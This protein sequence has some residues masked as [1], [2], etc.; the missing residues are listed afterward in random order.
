MSTFHKLIETPPILRKRS[1]AWVCFISTWLLTAC[2][3]LQDASVAPAPGSAAG[4]ALA[5]PE[6]ATPKQA[7]QKS[8]PDVITQ[9]TAVATA[10][11]LATQAGLRMLQAGGSAV[12]AAVSAQMVLGLVEPQSSGLG[13]GAFLLHSEGGLVQAWDGRETAP[14]QISEALLLDP[15][16]KPL[17]FHDAVVGGRSVGTPGVL[18]M[19][20]RVHQ[21]HGKLPWAQLFAPAIELANNGFEV[22]PRLHASLQADKFLRLDPTARA[23]FYQPQGEP[24][25]VGYRLR[26]P[27][28]AKVLQSIAQQGIDAFYKGEV[29]QAMVN[30]VQQHPTNPGLLQLSDLENY[31]SKQRNPLC[32][33]HTAQTRVYR[34]CGMPPPSSGAIAIGQILGQ[35]HHTPASLFG[36]NEGDI[37]AR[38]M[39]LYMESARLA[40][41]DRSVYVADPDFVTAPGGDWMN[42]LRPDYLQERAKLIRPTSMQQVP[43][44]NPVRGERSS[45][46][47]MLSQPEY[48]TSHMSIVDAKGNALAMTTT[49]EDAF[50]ARQMVKGFLLNNQLTD[51]SFAPRNAQGKEI[52]NRVQP[53]K[54]PRSSMSPTL[55]FDKATGQLVMS[56]GSPGGA[57]I[58]H[59][60]A[61][62]LY[63]VLHWGLTPQQAIDLPNFGTIGGPSVLEAQRFAPAVLQALRVRGAEVREQALPSGLQAIVR[64]PAAQG[65]GWMS[66]SDARREGVAA[67]D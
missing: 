32:F 9:R 64:M 49:I 47:P 29:A 53:N 38:W 33:D 2:N 30:K 34:I 35:L 25:P 51:F 19:L 5:Q 61:K 8:K 41:A 7:A 55:V 54:R 3:H 67:G 58:I 11:P 63:G 52:A 56:T 36:L 39:H 17:P 42:L 15:Q 37:D 65:K 22:S 26:N 66:G 60:T 57:V 46:A 23:Y 21:Q 27:D 50:G 62:T 4:P 20:W 43:V 13:G 6:I 48:G 12:D 59:Y 24:H 18:H 31:Q 45:W 10:H 44:G 1:A 16:G 40:F 28:Y 14:A